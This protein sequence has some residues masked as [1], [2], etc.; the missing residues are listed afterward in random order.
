MKSW[1]S[2]NE[3]LPPINFEGDSSFRFPEQLVEII[4]NEFSKPGDHVLDPFCGFGT[5]LVV[6]A[7][8]NRVGVGFEKKRTIFEFARRAVKPPNRIYND[9]AENIDK[10][11]FPLFDLLLCSPP[12]RSFRDNVLLDIE[13][14]YHDLL[15]IF[16]HIRPVL[17]RDAFVIV[18][19]I[20]LQRSSGITIPRAFKLMFTLSQL[21]EFEKEYICCNTSDSQIAEGYH[22]SYLMVF[23]NRPSIKESTRM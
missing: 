5:T 13:T 2:I 21:F 18:E 15:N 8:M 16:K 20:N 22:H 14:Y 12:F 11:S 6:C 23:R 1:L 17:K 4:L 9:N 19:T 7:K 10:Y 3:D